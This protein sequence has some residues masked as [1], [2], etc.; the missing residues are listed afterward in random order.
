MTTR[1]GPQPAPD[2]P[3]IFK[4]T[5]RQFFEE[6]A[7][8]IFCE[9]CEGRGFL[10]ESV[11]GLF[12][13]GDPRRY[14]PDNECCSPEEIAW[15]QE[16]CAQWDAGHGVD[17]GP[18]CA[19][20]GDASA[21]TGTGFGIGVYQMDG[22]DPCPECAG[23]GFLEEG[24]MMAVR[25]KFTCIMVSKVKGWG[26]HEFLWTAHFQPVTGHGDGESEENKAF[27]AATP[28]GK[29]ELTSVLHDAFEVGRD[30]YL[31]ITPAPVAE[32]WK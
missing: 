14:S 25:A 29:L 5:P 13:G 16:A 2:D 28:A 31:D 23:R 20:M 18:S 7:R 8:T 22:S 24:G 17:R 15:H 1:F 32:E 10:Q 6:A 30:Y 11:Y 9:W 12:P 26:G 21:W 4:G 19:T 27:W 3:R